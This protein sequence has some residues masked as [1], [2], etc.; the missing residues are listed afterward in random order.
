M[1]LYNARVMPLGKVAVLPIVVST[2]V[3]GKP[4]SVRIFLTTWT[5]HPTGFS[6]TSESASSSEFFVPR[7]G[8][9]AAHEAVAKN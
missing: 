2:K 4:I 1:V 6:F 5:L 3:A 7:I 9:R 8:P